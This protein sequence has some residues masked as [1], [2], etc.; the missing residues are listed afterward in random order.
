MTVSINGELIRGEVARSADQ[1][2]LLASQWCAAFI[3]KGWNPSGPERAPGGAVRWTL[4]RP[5]LDVLCESVPRAEGGFDL[6]LSLRGLTLEREIC[7]AVP[8]SDEQATEWRAVVRGVWIRRAGPCV[9]EE[10]LRVVPV[11]LSGLFTTGYVL[12]LRM[13][14][15]LN[16]IWFFAVL[17]RHQRETASTS[18]G[19]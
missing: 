6:A 3:D 12:P 7:R 5:G 16:H 14:A 19:T 2:R 10:L 8:G 18:R 13:L 1:A 4:H 15:V 17:D 9:A 11:S